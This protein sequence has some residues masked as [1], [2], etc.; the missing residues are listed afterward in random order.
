M[1]YLKTFEGFSKQELDNLISN[2][3]AF[4]YKAE[5]KNKIIK[6]ELVSKIINYDFSKFKRENIFSGLIIY[7]NEDFISLC[8]KFINDKIDNLTFEVEILNIESGSYIKHNFIDVY[9]LIPDNLQGLSIGYNLYK[10][11]LSYDDVNFLTSDNNNSSSAKNLWYNLLQDRDLYSAINDKNCVI[12]N[13]HISDD[14]LINILNKLKYMNL[15]YDKDLIKFINK[16]G[17]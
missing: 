6:N 17:I 16:H 4:V 3:K 5:R 14:K 15:N 12:I 10:L 7:P 8:E 9:K 2:N 11:I 1:L 13:K